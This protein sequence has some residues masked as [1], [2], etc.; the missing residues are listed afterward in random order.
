MYLQAGFTKHQE[1]SPDYCYVKA[2]VRVSKR[3]RQKS[4]FKAHPEALYDP[5][6]TES[7]LATLNGYHRLWFRGKVKWSLAV[8]EPESAK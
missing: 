3:S 4:W 2:R 5:A 8:P 1:G 6:L 7:E